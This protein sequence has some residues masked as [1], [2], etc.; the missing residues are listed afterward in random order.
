MKRVIIRQ[1]Q[2]ADNFYFIISGQA[3]VT[4]M[5]MDKKSNEMKNRILAVL[6]AGSGFGELA[7]LYN[8]TRAATVST[9]TDMELI[10]IGR[11]DF[12]DIFMSNRGEEPEHIQFL[13]TCP[14][15]KY[16]P[17]QVLLE[18]PSKCVFHYY[19]YL[20][21]ILIIRKS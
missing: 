11:A 1:G 4:L 8:T 17:I 13:R 16:W 6:K 12:F 20:K 5:D 2:V 7:F 9:L 18:Q 3:I 15:I 10:S 21:E 14:F 19:K